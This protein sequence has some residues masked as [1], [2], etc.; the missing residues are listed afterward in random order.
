VTQAPVLRILPGSHWSAFPPEIRQRFLAAHYLVTKNSDRMGYRLSGPPL[1]PDRPL[2]ID[3]EPVT[4]GSIQIP[5]DGAPIVLMADHPTQG[6]Y[7]RLAEIIGTDVGT[8]AQCR[9]GVK[10]EFREVDEQTALQARREWRR[11]LA[12]LGV[13]LGSGERDSFRGAALHA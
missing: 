6:G 4:F 1:H 2:E 5:P 3:S 9:P 11:S 8:L 12:R 7:P 10:V 13:G